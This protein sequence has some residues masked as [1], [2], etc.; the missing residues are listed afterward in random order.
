MM[1]SASRSRGISIVAIIQSFAQLEKHYDEEGCEIIVDNCQLTIFG[2]FAPKSKSA[3]ELSK[4]MGTYTVLTGSVTRA[5]ENSKS[6][7]MTERALMTADE[8]KSIKKGNFIVL[9]TG[10]NP[11]KSKFK[12]FMK[13]G[14]TFKNIF[15]IEEQNERVV[16]YSSKDELSLAIK[17]SNRQ[18]INKRSLSTRVLKETSFEDDLRTD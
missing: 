10:F 2:G 12:L 9:K 5:R 16:F 8:I 15:V 3:E 14:I 7:Q 18:R 17:N 11:M 4:S 13:W 1:F 6:L